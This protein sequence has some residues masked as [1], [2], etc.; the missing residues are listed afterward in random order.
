MSLAPLPDQL[1]ICARSLDGS[2]CRGTIYR[3][4]VDGT[5]PYCPK[6]WSTEPGVI[7]VK[8][9]TAR[10]SRSCP[11]IA[12]IYPCKRHRRPATASGRRA[13]TVTAR[14]KADS[15]TVVRQ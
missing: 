14:R 5:L 2:A 7:Y 12:A 10:R 3:R 11:M 4:G 9:G 8:V 15:E 1:E 13:V 6:V